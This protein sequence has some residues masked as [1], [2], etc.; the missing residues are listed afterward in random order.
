MSS[1]LK[2]I[3][4]LNWTGNI[5][6]AVFCIVG[7]RV[8]VLH[9]IAIQFVKYKLMLA[10]IINNSHVDVCFVSNCS[11]FVYVRLTFRTLHQQTCTLQHICYML[12]PTQ[13]KA[14]RRTPERTNRNNNFALAAKRVLSNCVACKCEI[15]AY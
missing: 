1:V 4:T 11:V 8:H 6:A 5:F 14:A 7:Q 12:V 15:T 13:K 10:H 3:E 2:L 9:M